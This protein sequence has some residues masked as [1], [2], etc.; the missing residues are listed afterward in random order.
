MEESD[1]EEAAGIACLSLLPEKSKQRYESC[2]EGFKKW[3]HTKKVVIHTSETVLLAYFLEKSGKYSAPSSL[4]SEY[5]MLRATISLN[6]NVDISKYA[7]LKAFL[8][9]K[10]IGYVSKKSEVFTIEEIQTFLSEAH[11]QI[12]LMK[13]VVVVMGIAGAC[14]KDELCKLTINNV[15]DKGD[16]ILVRI[17]DAK[18]HQSRSFTIV[19][20][21]NE[22]FHFV[23][24]VRKYMNLR[25]KSSIQRFFLRY[26][27]G[28]CS[29]QPV[30]RNIFAKIPSEVA[31]FLH[32][33]N[34]EKYTGHSFRRTSATF[35]ANS[36]V[37]ILALKR[38]G[39]WKSSAVAESYVAD[40]LN[41]KVQVAKKIFHISNQEASSS[42]Q[43]PIIEVGDSSNT[44][45]D[46][47][48]NLT[49]LETEDN[50]IKKS[51]A[52]ILTVNHMTNCTFNI[53]M[54]YNN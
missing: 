22:K 51:M 23:A 12:Y 14:R 40:S 31:K 3:C 42:R 19:D 25:P 27:N 21:E 33:E 13:K 2:Y 37:D 7:K 44:P 41:N 38:H 43:I 18:N 5:S 48:D 11:D 36:G 24:L 6:D 45:Q 9:K 53:S 34:A 28:K 30:G 4:W 47:L 10:N 32:L 20:N 1:I 35:L 16:I 39:G 49:L 29:N 17:L 52:S 46:S 54:N 50:N 15:I 8:K 26:Q